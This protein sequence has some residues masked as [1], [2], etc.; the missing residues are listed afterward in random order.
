MAL[1]FFWCI[2]ADRCDL[3]FDFI[4]FGDNVLSFVISAE[5]IEKQHSVDVENETGCVRGRGMAST[6]FDPYSAHGGGGW[7]GRGDPYGGGGA[8]ADL[9]VQNDPY[10]H[11]ML[12]APPPAS[13]RGQSSL[14]AVAAA[15]SASGGGDDASFARDL[16]KLYSE[17]PVAFD[18][19]ARDPVVRRSMKLDG[20][21]SV[22]SAAGYDDVGMTGVREL[23]PEPRLVATR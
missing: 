4:A 21:E 15:G 6:R 11:A 3:S 9:Y 10:R 17:N 19:Y 1:L 5:Y 18:A 22:M 12:H 7:M 8:S 20:Q 23:Y 16:L 13:V 14:G 2:Q